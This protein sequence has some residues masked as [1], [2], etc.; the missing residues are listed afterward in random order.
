MSEEQEEW[1]P[2][3]GYEGLYEVSNFGR[4]RNSKRMHIL[5]AHKTC[6]YYRVLLCRPPVGSKKD[7]KNWLV[8]RLVAKAFIPNLKAAPQ[9]DH[10][11]GNR[12]DNRAV[13]LRWV[14]CKENHN[15]PITQIMNRAAHYTAAARERAKTVLNTPEVIA[16]RN[17]KL[18]SEE[19]RRKL[20][21]AHGKR[22]LC[23]ETGVVYM[24][25]CDAARAYNTGYWNIKHSCIHGNIDDPVNDHNPKTLEH[26]FIFYNP[27]NQMK[28]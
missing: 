24:S 3:V 21:I 23:L 6:G 16:K 9:V 8:H 25:M 26:H 11:N 18:K 13:N 27:N 12:E 20:A 22:I 14:T 7:H 4:V 1:R 17:V 5:A 15:N 28:E 19:N 10:I 2:V